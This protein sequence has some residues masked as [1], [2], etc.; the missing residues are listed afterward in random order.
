MAGTNTRALAHA[1]LLMLVTMA[2]AGGC[3]DSASPSEG[4]DASGGSSTDSGSN[5]GDAPGTDGTADADTGPWRVLVFS[6]TQGFRH[7]SI[8]DG[9]AMFE[10]LAQERGFEVTFTEDGAAFSDDNLAG[11]AVV[12]WLSTTGD[13]LSSEQELAF[14]RYMRNGGGYVGIHAASDTEYEW[15][16]YGRLVGAYFRSHPSIQDAGVRI[17]DNAH[18]A[19]AHLD[20][21]WMRRDEWYNFRENPRDQVT[22]LLALDEATYGGGDM[23]DHPIAWSHEN[24]GGRAFYTALGHT[25][26]SYEEPAFRDHIAGA[27]TWAARR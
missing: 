22:V 5:N 8:A 1:C 4:S 2:Q 9:I 7:D 27:V 26:E 12:V 20:A 23:G 3:G 17:E 10:A 16:F 13:V 15:P 19:T 18:P 24:E 21:T 25:S 14:E 6:R 11:Y